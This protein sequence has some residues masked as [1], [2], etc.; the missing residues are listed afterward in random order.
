M[1]KNIPDRRQP[2]LWFH[3]LEQ[4]AT[5][6]VSLYALSQTNPISGFL[7]VEM[8][9]HDIEQQELNQILMF[10]KPAYCLSTIGGIENFVYGGFEDFRQHGSDI[11]SVFGPKPVRCL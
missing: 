2:F 9:H 7:A 8:G 6:T 1:V 11:G 5:V 4:A 3:R 10:L